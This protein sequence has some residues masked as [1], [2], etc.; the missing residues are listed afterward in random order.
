MALIPVSADPGADPHQTRH[1]PFLSFTS[2]QNSPSDQQLLINQPVVCYCIQMYASVYAETAQ[3]FQVSAGASASLSANPTGTQAGNGTASNTGT[4]SLTAPRMLA[5]VSAAVGNAASGTSGCVP[6]ESTAAT[7]TTA[8]MCAV[9]SA[10]A[11]GSGTGSL[12]VDDAHSTSTTDL[13][14]SFSFAAI[15]VHFTEQAILFRFDC[16]LDQRSTG[17]YSSLG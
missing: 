17:H 8:M 4:T 6:V 14:A 3:A 9:A 13:Y 2:V 12:S 10:A 5:S 16:L 11:S 15:F 7:A 1:P